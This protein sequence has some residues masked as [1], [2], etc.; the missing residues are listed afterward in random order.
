MKTGENSPPVMKREDVSDVQNV[1]SLTSK[2]EN[3]TKKN[4]K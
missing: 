4:I 1:L 2:R 3:K